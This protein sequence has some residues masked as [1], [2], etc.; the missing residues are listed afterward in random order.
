MLPS[1]LSLCGKRR[2]RDLEG[3][4][5]PE[6]A[7]LQ[8]VLW[9]GR[10]ELCLGESVGL[11]PLHLETR[12]HGLNEQPFG[13]E[14]LGNSNSQA[15]PMHERALCQSCQTKMLDATRLTSARRSP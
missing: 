12:V 8:A 15:I 4:I 1:S 7:R 14:G 5:P 6:D 13:Y 3:K 2:R 11:P 9:G 10:R